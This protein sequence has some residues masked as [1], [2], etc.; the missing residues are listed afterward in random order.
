MQA[1]AAARLKAGQRGAGAIELGDLLLGLIVA[2][3]DLWANLLPE[4]REGDRL[5]GSPPHTPFFS[6]EEASKL[7]NGIEAVLPHSGPVGHTVELPLSHEVQLAFDEAERIQKTFLQRQIE[8]LHLLAAV[9]TQEGSQC[10]KLLLTEGITKELVLRKL[11]SDQSGS[12]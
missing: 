6:T 4:M 10:V 5:I 1:L 11:T 7:L 12:S 8:P 2:D 9:L 3:Q